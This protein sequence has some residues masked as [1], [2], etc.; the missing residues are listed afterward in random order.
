MRALEHCPHSRS[1]AEH[2][3]I[4]IR[5]ISVPTSQIFFATALRLRSRIFGDFSKHAGKKVVGKNI[6]LNFAT[7]RVHSNRMMCNVVVTYY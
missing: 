1:T 6:A 5:S 2:K 3:Q 7:T 4:A